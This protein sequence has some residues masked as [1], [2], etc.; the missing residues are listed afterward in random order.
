MKLASN[1]CLA[2][3]FPQLEYGDFSGDKNSTVQHGLTGEGVDKLF[4]AR[5]RNLSLHGIYNVNYN[6]SMVSLVL[7]Q[8][9][10]GENGTESLVGFFFLYCLFE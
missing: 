7:R 9:M 1:R 3:T 5:F 2:H 10:R 4:T 8:Y 6:E